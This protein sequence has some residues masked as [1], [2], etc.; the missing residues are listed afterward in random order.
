[1]IVNTI[2]GMGAKVRPKGSDRCNALGKC[3]KPDAKPE[4]LMV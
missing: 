2:A 4:S 3:R 1:M